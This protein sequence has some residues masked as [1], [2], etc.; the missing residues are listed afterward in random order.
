M[1]VEHADQRACEG[2][3]ALR[4]ELDSAEMRALGD[5]DL[6]V[7]VDL[8]R[9]YHRALV[10]GSRNDVLAEVLQGLRQRWTSFAGKK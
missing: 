8:D 2:L 7:H 9:D 5:R 1:L 6:R 10:E 3:R 4:S